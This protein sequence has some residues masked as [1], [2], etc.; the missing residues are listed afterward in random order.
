MML[1]ENTVLTAATQVCCCKLVF[2]H[3]VS[4]AGPQQ[5]AR[6]RRSSSDRRANS[7]ATGDD[8]DDVNMLTELCLAATS[9]F[10]RG[11]GRVWRNFQP[12]QTRLPKDIECL[13]H[14]Y[15]GQLVSSAALHETQNMKT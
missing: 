8:A 2:T 12:T 11:G 14:K 9:I 6:S 7:V 5:N 15:A 13:F 10:K 1:A 3:Y 4:I